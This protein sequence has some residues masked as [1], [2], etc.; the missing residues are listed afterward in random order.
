MAGSLPPFSPPD[1]QVPTTLLQT[2][3]CALHSGCNREQE[4]PVWS[5]KRGSVLRKGDGCWVGEAWSA[6]GALHRASEEWA[7]SRGPSL[8]FFSHP[9]PFPVDLGNVT[10]KTSY[11]LLFFT[12]PWH[13]FFFSPS[14]SRYVCLDIPEFLRSTCYFFY[15]NIFPILMLDRNINKPKRGGVLERKFFF[16]F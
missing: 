7:W 16:V 15:T 11:V 10:Y 2:I 4:R 14:I 6:V 5:L 8:N 3:H 1:H 12:I 13:F 9:T